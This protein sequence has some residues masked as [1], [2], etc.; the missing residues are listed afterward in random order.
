MTCNDFIDEVAHIAAM[1]LAPAPP[2]PV[3]PH[4]THE[5]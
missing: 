1:C 2:I 4:Q 3:T 5:A